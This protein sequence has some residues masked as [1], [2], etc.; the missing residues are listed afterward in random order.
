MPSSQPERVHSILDQHL[1]RAQWWLGR[2]LG[3]PTTV[4]R[5]RQRREYDRR[6]AKSMEHQHDSPPT[7]DEE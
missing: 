1:R 5:N 2:T 3:E 4:E 6:L 7:D